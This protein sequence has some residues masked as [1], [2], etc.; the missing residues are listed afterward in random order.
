ST[1]A[2]GSGNYGI[3]VYPEGLDTNPATQDPVLTDFVMKNVTVRG[4]GRSEVDLLGVDGAVLTN[5]TADGDDTAGVGIAVSGSRN[6][7][8]V[9]VRTKGNQW[10]G[11]GL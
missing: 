8:L 4:F 3:K 10:G 9:G 2:G 5:V 7:A 11:V 1:G 6:V